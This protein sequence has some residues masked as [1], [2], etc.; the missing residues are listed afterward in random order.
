MKPLYVT[1]FPSNCKVH[2]LMEMPGQSV[3]HYLLLPIPQLLSSYLKW[4]CFVFWYCKK[5][6][7]LDYFPALNMVSENV[8]RLTSFLVRIKYEPMHK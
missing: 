5:N 7:I 2:T 6:V 8:K 4:C 1:I 3:Y